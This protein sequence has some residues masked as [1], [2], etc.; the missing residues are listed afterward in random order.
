[1]TMTMTKHDPMYGLETSRK[2]GWAKYYEKCEE[3]A[4]ARYTLT[5]LCQKILNHTRLHDDDDLVHLAS[6]LLYIIHE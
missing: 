6:R 1:M 5:M 3:L 2:V 4:E